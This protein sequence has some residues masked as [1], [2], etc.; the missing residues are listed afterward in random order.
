MTEQD[1]PTLNSILK[2]VKGS[3]I[4]SGRQKDIELE[5]LLTS[6]SEASPDAL[7]RVGLAFLDENPI[8][9]I[10]INYEE[11]RHLLLWATGNLGFNDGSPEAQYHV[12]RLYHEGAKGF[13]K[14]DIKAIEYLE[15]A[16]D[17][18]NLNAQFEAGTLRLNSRDRFV[19]SYIG[20]VKYLSMAANRGL[21]Q[22]QYELAN[23]YSE[24]RIGTPKSY[25]EMRKYLL[26]AAEQGM[27][28]A[29]YTL[30]M[31]YLNGEKGLPVDKNLANK[32]LEKAREGGIAIG[33]DIFL[34]KNSHLYQNELSAIKFLT[35]LA[36]NGDIES[37]RKLGI[38]YSTVGNEVLDYIKAAKWFGEAANKG[39]AFSQYSLGVLLKEG[40]GVEKNTSSAFDWFKMASDQGHPKAAWQIGDM[41]LELG[42][43]K[44]KYT[45]AEK[46]FR[47]AAELGSPDGQDSIGKFL[48]EGKG[49]KQDYEKAA[50]WYNK[51]AVQ[52]HLH[53]QFA[54][55]NM[56]IEGKGVKRDYE[57][58]VEFL[59]MASKNPRGNNATRKDLVTTMAKAIQDLTKLKILSGVDK[60]IENADNITILASTLS[61]IARAIDASSKHK[62]PS[63]ELNLSEPLPSKS[64]MARLRPDQG[65]VSD[66]GISGFDPDQRVA[67][68][69]FSWQKN[70]LNPETQWVTLGW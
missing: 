12:G 14:D 56:Y 2:K 11:A 59:T 50:E 39:D 68:S 49:V 45:K 27:A 31:L 46:W 30:G 63:S 19:Q 43:G 70:F 37:Q 17:N 60:I 23:I 33:N 24:R 28:E 26:M 13:P 8:E 67:L 1:K 9:G 16:A 54:L 35:T 7:L 64:I 58:A 51:A 32:W 52:G 21:A 29:Q 41:W 65:L 66:N 10:P 38:L 42:D 6:A 4:A 44:S 20:A 18:G 15:S 3:F 48:E 47:I 53:A 22:A 61:S 25:S 34:S 55:G 69:A 5:D 40:K 62:A 36:E 57:K